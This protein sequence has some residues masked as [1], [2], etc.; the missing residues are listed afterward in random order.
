MQETKI[1]RPGWAGLEVTA[2]DVSSVVDFVRGFTLLTATQPQGAFVEPA[3][4][5]LVTHLHEDHTDVASIEAA[6][7]GLDAGS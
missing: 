5:A 6:Q 2:Q 7:Y 1:Q 4:S 3:C